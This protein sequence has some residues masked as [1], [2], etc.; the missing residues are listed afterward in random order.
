MKSKP[1]KAR[2]RKPQ[3]KVRE[4]RRQGKLAKQHRKRKD[5]R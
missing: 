3:V 5:K 1:Q 2:K 4:K